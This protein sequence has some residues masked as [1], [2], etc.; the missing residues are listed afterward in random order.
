MEILIYKLFGFTN[1]VG[2]PKIVQLLTSEDPDVQIH[3]VKVVANLAA[4]GGL[5]GLYEICI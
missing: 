3:A 2:L 4:E 1:A 5:L